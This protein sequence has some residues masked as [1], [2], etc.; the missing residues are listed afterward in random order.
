MH[1]VNNILLYPT[2]LKQALRYGDF[3]SSPLTNLWP[4]CVFVFTY[5]F[6]G[7]NVSPGDRRVAYCLLMALGLPS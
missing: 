6:H 3:I 5:V 7:E 1:I 4:T 2:V